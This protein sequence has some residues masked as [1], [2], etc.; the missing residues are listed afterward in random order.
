MRAEAQSF[1]ADRLEQTNVLEAFLS[2][3]VNP[4]E[5]KKSLA[6]ALNCAAPPVV[7]ATPMDLTV[8]ASP[9]SPQQSAFE[10]L[11]SQVCP[12]A[13]PVPIANEDDLLF[14]RESCGI[15]LTSLP[16]FGP[17]GQEAYQQMLAV[18]HFTPHSRLDISEWL[19]PS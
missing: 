3:H 14:Y 7:S 5:T 12:D 19:T 6:Q 17:A 2:R 16:Q 18:P 1:V 13:A 15:D 8:V 10:D 9:P 11:L 4:E